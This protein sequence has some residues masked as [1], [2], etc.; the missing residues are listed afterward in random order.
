MKYCCGSAITHRKLGVLEVPLQP[1]NASSVTSLGQSVKGG[2]AH[3][4]ALICQGDLHQR[5]ARHG[6]GIEREEV[7]CGGAHLRVVALCETVRLHSDSSV[8]NESHAL[9]ES[10]ECDFLRIF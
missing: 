9:F 5:V 3:P 4:G 6:I 1:L 7:C 8:W 10:K 2:L